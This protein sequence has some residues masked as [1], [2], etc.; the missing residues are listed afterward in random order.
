MPLATARMISPGEVRDSSLLDPA[1]LRERLQQGEPAREILKKALVRGQEQLLERFR[2]GVPVDLL[3]AQRCWLVDEVLGIAWHVSGLDDHGCALAAVGGYG[4]GTLLPASDVDLLILTATADDEA[5][6]PAIEAFV[7]LLWDLKL[8]IG[9]AVRTPEQCAQE[10]EADIT[11]MTSLLESRL[12]TGDPALYARMEELTSPDRIWPTKAFF[13][14]KLEEQQQ[15]HQKY[16]DTA[17]SLEPNIKEGPGGLRDIQTITWVAKRHFGQPD[18]AG[19]VDHGFLTREEYQTLLSARSL[20]WRIRFA[21]HM[22]SGRHE[23]RLQFDYQRQI[24]ELFGFVPQNGESE[25]PTADVEQFMKLY[26]R[27]VTEVS[28]L[29]E[30]LLQLFEEAI[31]DSDASHKVV[32]INRR[33]QARGGFIEVTEENIFRRYPFALLEIFLLL[34]QHPELKGVRATT[35][36]LVRA[37]RDLI[38]SGFRSDLRCRSLFMEIIRQPRRLG[39]ELSRMHRYGI[40]ERYLPQ[41]GAVTG[42]MQFDLF[43]TYTVDEHT[44][45]VVRNLRRLT[46]PET[47]EE[48][49]LCGEVFQHIPKPELLYLAG[50]FHDIAKGRGGDHA[51]LGAEDALGFCLDHG[52]PQFDSRLVA[53]LVRNHLLMS[54]TSQRQDVQDPDVINRFA[55]LV[56]DRMHLDYLYLLTVADIRATNPEIWNSWKDALLE[57]LYHNTLRALRRGLENPLDKQERLE[58]V[59]GE[60]LARLCTAR[61][62]REEI[63]Q[64]W[65]TLG[66]EYFLRHDSAEIAWQ[67]RLILSSLPG[68]LPLV[69][70]FP[71][72]VFGGSAIFIYCRDRD[73]LFA[74]TTEALDRCGLTIMDARVITTPEGYALSTYVVLDAG[75]NEAITERERQLEV[76]ATVGEMLSDESAYASTGTTGRLG[77]RRQLR[78]FRIPTSV[79]FSVDPDRDR[80]IMELVANDS[81]GLLSRVGM[82]LRFCGA[83]LHNARIA[84]FGERVED[85]FLIS[86]LEDHAITDPVKQECLRH[87][88]V[89]ALAGT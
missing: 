25:R 89:E 8:D 79:S 84:T 58:E 4:R 63:E 46:L 76:I 24:A 64:L 49:P 82:A 39:H 22:L 41:F 28:R 55:R 2:M 42:L 11:V 74:L 17:Y 50:L 10:A 26:Y 29:N 31:L 54:L 53:W 13:R 16:G 66:E 75:T 86:D 30:M 5:H 59:K 52:L 62:R 14:A 33:F 27:H 87:T 68:D 85:I 15:R 45:L 83:R 70:F 77:S 69:A 37:H 56:G 71:E 57:T 9:H 7:T 65:S 40:L 1:A 47:A 73:F 12:L 61:L 80:T 21:L 72:P 78:Q 38:D 18:L 51:E 34:Q 60:A 44:L 81:P 23:D 3:V 35:V 36:R 88:I 48:L 67:T 19:L 6:G 43:H 20:L 32:P